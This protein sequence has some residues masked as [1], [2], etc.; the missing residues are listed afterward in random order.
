MSSQPSS[1]AILGDRL[2]LT[3]TYGWYVV[4]V[5]SFANIVSFVDRWI[6]TLMVGPIKADLGLTDTEMGMLLGFAFALFYAAMAVP[7]GMLADRRSRKMIILVGTILWSIATAACGLAKTFVQL[8]FTRVSVGVGEAT[9]SPSAMSMISDIFPREKVAKP[10][11]VFA[12]AGYSG[13][14]I[15]ILVGGYLVQMVQNAGPVDLPL[16]GILKPWQYTFLLVALPG[17]LVALLVSTLK[18][19][20]RHKLAAQPVATAMAGEGH[21]EK[22]HELRQRRIGYAFIL[23]GFPILAIMGYGTA[24][25]VP[26]FF[27]R[28]HGWQPSDIALYYGSIF[29]IC[30]TAGP[31]FGGW[32][33]DYLAQKGYKDANL[34]AAIIA[35]VALAPFA[36]SFP[37]VE[38]TTLAVILL[39]PTTFLGSVPFGT[40]T[41][42]IT[43][44][45]PPHRRAVM[46]AVYMLVGNLVGLGLGPVAVGFVTDHVFGNEMA[47]N[48]SLVFVAACAIPLGII[49]LWL[50]MKPFKASVEAMDKLEPSS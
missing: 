50:G 42:A 30:G 9:L 1:T 2:G 39:I 32:L 19:P 43:I 20:P 3:T 18:E 10:I 13:A 5:L 4:G 7:I 23:S 44:M 34:R 6:L 27:A 25:W 37:L 26:A 38:N 48:Y 35:T 16:L 40:S 24:S 31:L 29:L 15:A 46:V 47:I 8:F 12:A 17:V 28:L 36:L 41:S 22:T 45:T 11:S 49:L 33:T 14:G 21:E